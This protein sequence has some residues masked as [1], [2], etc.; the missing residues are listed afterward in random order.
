MN[1]T[2]AASAPGGKGL[3]FMIFLKQSRT[4]KSLVSMPEQK[5]VETDKM[6]AKQIIQQ[7]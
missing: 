1:R 6:K 5:A 3:A 4:K 2:A 7:L